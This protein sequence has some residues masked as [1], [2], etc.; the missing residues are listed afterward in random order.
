MTSI[1]GGNAEL[2]FAALGLVKPH[3]DAGKMRVLLI[4]HKIPAYPDAPTL[5]ELGYKEHLPPAW[6]GLYAPA[7][8]PE[9]ARKILVPA[10]EKAVRNSKPKIDQMGSICE[11]KTPSEQKKMWEEEYKRIY[12]IAVKIGLR[13]P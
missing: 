7:G 11:Y 1:L 10:V 6:F 8:I 3:I 4:T 5:P 2:T 9:E 12:E 13:K